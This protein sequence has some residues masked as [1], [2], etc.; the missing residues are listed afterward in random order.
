MRVR[1]EYYLLTSSQVTLEFSNI[2]ISASLVSQVRGQKENSREGRQEVS[3]LKLY[4][5]I[6]MEKETATHSSIL[7]R[8]IP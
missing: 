8:R 5:Q 6:C 3:V 1:K 4:K 7:A 2:E